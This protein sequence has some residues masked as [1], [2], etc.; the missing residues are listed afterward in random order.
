M[1][2]NSLAELADYV[3]RRQTAD[4]RLVAS[5]YRPARPQAPKPPPVPPPAERLRLIEQH[6]QEL[7][8]THPDKD[9]KILMAGLDEVREWKEAPLNYPKVE[10]L[11][12]VG[13]ERMKRL[14][15]KSETGYDIAGGL[16]TLAR[17]VPR[18]LD[19]TAAAVM[20]AIRA[21][22][23]DTDQG[24]TDE[25]L[26]RQ[27]KDAEAF[28]KEH[29]SKKKVFPETWLTPEGVTVED[30]ARLPQ[31][32]GFTLASALAGLGVGVPTALLP[33]PG[34]RVAAWA[35]GTGASGATAYRMAKDQIVSDMYDLFNEQ[36]IENKG[37]TL[38]QEEWSAIKE[39]YDAEATEY[40][41][42]EAIPEA[43]G[44][45]LSLGIIRVPVGKF[46][47]I[48][49]VKNRLIRALA[50]GT[51]KFA[52]MQA[53]EQTTETL[54]GYGQAGIEAKM[55]LRDN[56]L[57]LA[58]AAR[59]QAAQTF[60]L[61]SVMGGA[62]AVGSRVYDRTIGRKAAP[63]DGQGGTTAAGAVDEVAGSR[64]QGAGSA[65]EGAQGRPIP[66]MSDAGAEI[67]DIGAGSAEEEAEAYL[68]R[69]LE[70]ARHEGEEGPIEPGEGPMPEGP[71]S[72]MEGVAAGSPEVVEALV[73]PAAAPPVEEAAGEGAGET[74]KGR[75]P[76]VDM[77]LGRKPEEETAEGLT[78][79]LD[80][81]ARASLSERYNVNPD[82]LEFLAPWT[83]GHDLLLYNIV[84]K[85]H[86]S[87][88]STVA[89]NLK[90]EKEGLP[91]VEKTEEVEAEEKVVPFKERSPG[92]KRIIEEYNKPMTTDTWSAAYNQEAH[93][94]E[95]SEHS[96]L[97]DELIR[98]LEREK[99]KKA[100]ILEIGTGNGRDS[101]FFAK[102][103]H[104]ATGVDVASKA[105]Q[106]AKDN[107][108][109]VA[110]ATFQ[111]GDAEN[112]YQFEDG[113]VD[114]VYSVAAL[115]STPIKFTFG[116]IFRV[117][118]PGGQAKLFLYT[119]TKT[120]DKWVSYWTPGEI[121]QYAKEAGFRVEKF[122]EGHDANP[123]EIPG[124][125]GKVEQETHLAITTLRKPVRADEAAEKPNR[126]E[127]AAIRMKDGT[128]YA[129]QTHTE[130]FDKIP[131]NKRADIDD[132]DGFVDTQGNF[133][134]RD[135]A[136]DR[137]RT[138][139][140]GKL[141]DGDA[142]VLV[143]QDLEAPVESQE[144]APDVGEQAE[145]EIKRELGAIRDE[146]N[147][148]IDEL[149][150]GN[151]GPMNELIRG[152]GS[153]IQVEAIRRV[154]DQ[155]GYN[156]D[157]YL[158][159]TPYSK[160]YKKVTPTI[161]EWDKDV[162][163]VE[164]TPPEAPKPVRSVETL[165]GKR[166]KKGEPRS[167]AEYLEDKGPPAP[168]R[169]I[170]TPGGMGF[171][172][173]QT[174]LR[175][176]KQQRLSEFDYSLMRGEDGYY[177]REKN[178]DDKP[179][180]AQKQALYADQA[181]ARRRILAARAT[182]F[183]QWVKYAGGIRRDDSTFKGE[184]R[185]GAKGQGGVPTFVFRKDGRGIDEM[186]QEAIE[187]G[188]LAPDSTEQD[189]I[190]ALIN[191]KR[192][193]FS[194]LAD[195][196]EDFL[197][198]KFANEYENYAGAEEDAQQ[199]KDRELAR[200][201]L[202]QGLRDGEKEGLRQADDAAQG[203]KDQGV[204]GGPDEDGY[205]WGS[206]EYVDLEGEQGPEGDDIDLSAWD[207]VSFGP[208]PPDD[209]VREQQS[210]F[211]PAKQQRFELTPE[212][213]TEKEKL[214]RAQDEAKRKG[215]Q[216]KG[217]R[218]V[219]RHDK[220]IPVG[221]GGRQESLFGS[222][223]G[224]QNL[225]DAGID[226]PGKEQPV[227]DARDTEDIP[228]KAADAP[229]IRLEGAPSVRYRTSGRIKAQGCVVSGLDD[230]A[231]LLARLRTE[232]DEYFYS[233]AVDKD[234]TILEIHEHTKG[235]RQS[236]IVI[237]DT[238]MGRALRIPGISKLYF[239]HA[240]PSISLKASDQDKDITGRLDRLAR[241]SG[242]GTESII[243]AGNQ[244][245]PLTEG[246]A[247]ETAR[248]TPVLRKVTIDKMRRRI[249]KAARTR[250]PSIESPH[251][252]EAFVK[253]N[254]N[255]EDGIL[256]MDGQNRPIAFLPFVKGRTMRQM[257][258]DILKL[259]EETNAGAL[260]VK[261]DDVASKPRH[262]YI[263][264]LMGGDLGLLKFLDVIENGQS[265]AWNEIPG[266]Y[267]PLTP[268]ERDRRLGSTTRRLF[269]RPKKD[270]KPPRGLKVKD[271][272]GL[273]DQ[274]RGVFA[275]LRV[276]E[277]RVLRTEGDL[278]ADVARRAAKGREAL[279]DFLV[280]GLYDVAPGGR[281]T[282]Y[283]FADAMDSQN[284]VIEVFVHEAFH[285][286]V[287]T[288]LG[289]SAKGV[290]NSIYKDH[291]TAIDRLAADRG[292]DVG[293]EA[294]RAE[295]AE[296]WIV[297]GMVADTLPRTVWDRI[298]RAVRA[299][300]RKAGIHLKYGYAELGLGTR[301]RQGDVRQ[302]I[303]DAVVGGVEGSRLK[304]EGVKGEGGRLETAGR[305]FL[306]LPG[307]GVVYRT[308]V[309]KKGMEADPDWDAGK[310]K[311]DMAAARRFAETHWEDKKTLA[312]KEKL[313][314][315]G[316]ALFISQPSS[317]RQNVHP[318]AL[319]ERI[320]RETGGV[321]VD[322]NAV[323]KVL[324]EQQS[325]KIP[326]KDR[327][328]H[329][330]E[331]KAVDADRLRDLA[332][333]REVV[334]V[335]DILTSGGSVAAL[336][337]KLQALGV[338]VSTVTAYY[339]EA[340][341]APDTPTVAA[342]SRALR[343]ARMP[344]RAGEL[345]NLLT[346]SEM[347]DIIWQV[348]HAR[349]D[350][351]RQNLSQRLQGLRDQRTA[352]DV[353]SDQGRRYSQ[354]DTQE[355]DRGHGRLSEGVQ[356]GHT[357][358]D[359]RRRVPETPAKPSISTEHIYQGLP[360]QVRERLEKSGRGL[361]REGRIE[362]IR[363]GAVD[364]LRLRRHFEALGRDFGH[365]SDPLRVLEGSQERSRHKA[366]KTL[367]DI[368]KGLETPEN[369]RVF[370]LSIVMD[371]M[372]RDLD[373]GLLLEAE[374]TRSAERGTRSGA[375]ETLP[376]GFKSRGEVEAYRDHLK[377]L[378][379]QTPKI[380]KA[381]DERQEYMTGL[382]RDL[383]E[384][385]L[386]KP[387]TLQDDAYF[388]HQVLLYRALENLDQEYRFK[389]K[390]REKD[391]RLHRQGWQRARKGSL[392][393]YSTEYVESEFEV[394][395]QALHQLD[396]K[397]A[398]DTIEERADIFSS[399]KQAAKHA[400]LTELYR[401]NPNPLEDPLA[402]F[403][404]RIAI[405]TGELIQMAG[406]E[407]K[408]GGLYEAAGTGFEDVVS[409]MAEAHRE[410]LEDVAEWKEAGGKRGTGEPR[411]SL[412]FDHPRWFPFL[413]H[414]LANPGAGSK[415]AAGI[416]KAILERNR[417][418]EET[419]GKDLKTWRDMIPEGYVAW[420]PRPDGV[421]FAVNAV[422]DQMLE[423]MRSG[424]KPIPERVAH[425]FARVP[426]K[427]WVIPK[428]VAHTLDHFQEP[429]SG[430]VI[431]KGLRIAQGG[432]KQWILLNPFRVI[433]YNI[434]NMSGD[435]D[436]AM[437]YAPKIIS[438]YLPRAVKDLAVK[439]PSKEVAAEL[440]EARE[441]DVLGSGW[442][443]QEAHD[444]TR[445]LEK[446]GLLN[447]LMNKENLAQKYW[448]NIKR[449]T[450]FRENLLRLAA[451]RYFKD[452]IQAGRVPGK[453]LV[454]A[455]SRKEIEALRQAGAKRE[456]IAAKLARELIGDYGNVSKGGQWLRSYALP[457]WSWLEINAPR[458]VRLMWNLPH[459]GK[460]AARGL[461]AMGIQ[462]GWRGAVL[463]I[464]A[465]M[466]YGAIMLWNRLMF[467]D[468]DDEMD[469]IQRRDL[470]IILGRREDGSIVSLR[471]EGALADALEWL[472]LQ[473]AVK[474]LEEM[475]EGKKT[476]GDQVKEMMKA[477]GQRLLLASRPDVKGAAELIMGRSLFPDPEFPRPIRDKWEHVASIFSLQKPYQWAAGKPK[478][479]R[480]VA[481]RLWNDVL[482]MGFYTA[483][484]GEMAY[485]NTR[486]AVIDWQK[487]RQKEPSAVIP[488]DTANA[489]YYYKQALRYGDLKAA[490]GYLE[491]YA[492]L[493][494]SL[495]GMDAS[496]RAASPLWG[497]GV[498][499]RE[500]FLKGLSTEERESLDRATHWYSAVYK[501]AARHLPAVVKKMTPQALAEFLKPPVVSTDPAHARAMQEINR[502]KTAG[503]LPMGPPARTISIGGTPRQ[504][505]DDQY[506]AYME[507]SSALTFS[508]L[509]QIVGTDKWSRMPD[510]RKAEVV[511]DIVNA[512][513]KRARSRVKRQMWGEA[514]RKRA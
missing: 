150:D 396:V 508:R 11:E 441:R 138:W 464:K 259:A 144:P 194:D 76:S 383:V 31:N 311:G 400:N 69:I 91:Q 497:I 415:Q 483:D 297:D 247:G 352:Q 430:D 246:G 274:L 98:D 187:G 133:L 509:R 257:T 140:G 343:N 93:W 54:T 206:G 223:A 106:L 321:S 174:A 423:Q 208:K 360:A 210:L 437:A 293:T 81:R 401:R 388:H 29:G 444:V 295:A 450:V 399:C 355:E 272:Q 280:R 156:A 220:G 302:I 377:K 213:L 382:K 327:A 432:W 395:S 320:A 148:A 331:Y 412:S 417:L 442:A 358:R 410:Y 136:L 195:G 314:D 103:G 376:F 455:S 350:N 44:Q 353:G 465:S 36:S 301:Y 49:A 393:D 228:L 77:L 132:A 243:I 191:D 306:E 252:M 429:P 365:I 312:I 153:D 142:R 310:N 147:N 457:F 419:L 119:R 467:P 56:P 168:R 277:V 307:K 245:V 96:P 202:S 116:E 9:P 288:G 30:V 52:A 290:F 470:H 171:K 282:I 78:P 397:A 291:A 163:N 21:G 233:V 215:L 225:F 427:K 254:L 27:K 180:P 428:E 356:A 416:F 25:F 99:V 494:G 15:P 414:L 370:E 265:H 182:S 125:K 316:N 236:S 504:M 68:E 324:H 480:D 122:R 12:A 336:V 354:G 126:I 298:I 398:M 222:K 286:G 446:E 3:R 462:L 88:G 421:W 453:D 229:G 303:R 304:A 87:Y 378:I 261:N 16:G 57:T 492:E 241:I 10:E 389:E 145:A 211:G 53:E 209:E 155:N 121:K 345:K 231:S 60:L 26:A 443:L 201:R 440:A 40:G 73:E 120:G 83:N 162:I 19:E 197:L 124:V 80:A 84:N 506:E 478:R 14:K 221:T 218:P 8:K 513:R 469:E 255:N 505:T 477:P 141:P 486:K 463:G 235:G 344:I 173:R 75:S 172:T 179:T 445:F 315:P 39:K 349:T 152:V 109:D 226:T 175:Q 97:A 425:V 123:I 157:R 466:L 107:A 319:S 328:F 176:L 18:V 196:N 217:P 449:F 296:E 309:D 488:S 476:G 491:K 137:A 181:K 471:F 405:N 151:G 7:I 70:E 411:P 371:D 232:P 402:P 63:D 362:R 447:V 276:D 499:D 268:E 113:S 484:P 105:I 273:A 100:N 112:L 452:Q 384:A 407:V 287:K 454:G 385:D 408:S 249:G 82:D 386:L 143:G 368:L 409:D 161:D 490:H 177:W 160:G 422:T 404:Q 108:K 435:L 305:K 128:L 239:A 374:G 271:V 342:M 294:G 332:A 507:R 317:S 387:E 66:P 79:D 267:P 323:F 102:K 203:R 205:D 35:A 95:D 460:S 431:S 379:D 204:E 170:R 500:T 278:E 258:V 456:E 459:E 28:V 366:G 20:S 154:L 322:G 34:A 129:G 329:P 212:E 461:A 85:D 22:D 438:H 17:A 439:A 58:E 216:K 448:K 189:F 375:E 67:K 5:L 74:G 86:P 512:A 270:A 101:I 224:Q 230:L 472:N 451:Y 264:A 115:H 337:R 406:D 94:T 426:G 227:Y 510:A 184:L 373:S 433:K 289:D 33:V 165:T 485:W 158:P 335:D 285:D 292:L 166:L 207:D 51:A 333:G 474:D 501:D 279:G 48:P 185:D 390:A 193:K 64:G 281:R 348:N 24:W 38:T 420:D 363:R 326:K 23:I 219:F 369:K 92:E 339:G 380:Q 71:P 256:L 55:G 41:L 183:R 134:K 418:I 275:G 130:A 234:G 359:V 149:K 372:L 340:R 198:D 266:R 178:D 135:E 253:D 381:L 192:D 89:F 110:N 357:R 475:A 139:S 114:A 240:H 283:L 263:Q 146:L 318:L 325:K 72:Q 1:A 299:I 392:L 481:Q 394:I 308:V 511:R 127:S 473:D 46:L 238:V 186:T 413:A 248:I 190:D 338:S 32:I 90:R 250:F 330:R 498:K 61:T 47:K 364:V 502:L 482:S 244:Y 42:W 50:S 284:D 503:V 468:E 495:Q 260:A 242:I 300:L 313:E 214:A 62:G 496:V 43:A 434:N 164:P 514:Q 493:G 269:A 262:D 341:L 2:T 167:G 188:W 403:R 6:T 118:K 4:E 436:I 361:G 424:Q 347:R 367:T 199:R 13:T 159:E 45:A 200:L 104:L 489:L 117:L 391:V 65:E 479:G 37:R 346:R 131:M 351:A 59:E 169:E 251:Q 237:P 111:E 458:Y 487:K 334:V